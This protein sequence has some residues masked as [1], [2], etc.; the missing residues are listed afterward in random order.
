MRTKKDQFEM[1]MKGII[2]SCAILALTTPLLTTTTVPSITYAKATFIQIFIEIACAAWIL[3]ILSSQKHRLNWRHPIILAIGIFLLALLVTLPFSVDPA[4]SFWSIEMRM[5]GVFGL[6]HYLLV[7]LILASTIKTWANW[8]TLFLY[9]TFVCLIVDLSGFYQMI[10]TGI[11]R[12]DST[13]GN[14]L[15]YAAYVLLHIF[16]GLLLFTREKNLYWKYALAAIISFHIVGLILANSRGPLLALIA[17]FGSG[18]LFYIFTANSRRKKIK[19]SIILIALIALMAGSVYWLRLPGHRD[20]GQF[21]PNAFQRV[22]Y[23]N[24]QHERLF[25]WNYAWQGFTEKP[26]AG[27]GLENSQMVVDKYYNPDDIVF[28]ERWHNRFHNQYFEILNGTGVIGFAA[29]GLLWLSLFYALYRKYRTSEER[30]DKLAVG[31]VGMLFVAYLFQGITMFDLP[32]SMLVLF[33]VIGY[34][35]SETPKDSER[36]NLIPEINPGVI[37]P[38]ILFIIISLLAYYFSLRPLQKTAAEMK[39][40]QIILNS[41]PAALG[42][43]QE[44]LSVHDPYND[45]IRLWMSSATRL[46]DQYLTFPMPDGAELAYFTAEQMAITA[47][48]KP[49]D[50]QAQLFNAFAQRFAASYNPEYRQA[51]IEAANATL[52]IIPQHPEGYE[53]LAELYFA[54]G[55]YE[56]AHDYFQQALDHAFRPADKGRLQIR[57]ASL[58]ATQGDYEGALEWM[59][60]P[61]NGFDQAK[62]PRL[63]LPLAIAAPDGQPNQEAL[64][65]AIAVLKVHNTHPEVIE[66]LILLYKKAGNEQT[67]AD[68][69]KA[70]YQLYPAMAREFENQYLK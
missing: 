54:L 1:W 5:M 21:L 60:K 34:L 38:V 69:L 29:Y 23:L 61:H 44:A 28:G 24:L 58:I 68:N 19:Y 47:Q 37:M 56:L 49:Y 70:L 65:H 63:A 62:E 16:I 14:P 4:K 64:D 17:A 59:I 32:V 51:A 11:T 46:V 33:S 53:E 27:W 55:E 18:I 12:V 31:A 35:I 50:S 43:F 57:M 67:V 36:E 15:Y 8:R 41:R 13:L 45:D 20:A 2:W 30:D 26:I 3:L 52:A 6:A 10:T 40:H 9:S 48:N 22:I 66:A 25:L 39:G 42:Y 7:A